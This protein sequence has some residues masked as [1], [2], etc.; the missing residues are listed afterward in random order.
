[1]SLGDD[2][3]ECVN[4]I[5]Q[6]LARVP[7]PDGFLS[8]HVVDLATGQ[9]LAGLVSAEGA[10]PDRPGEPPDTEHA[11]ARAHAAAAVLTQTLQD[12]GGV[13]AVHS[14][15]DDLEDLA[16]TTSRHHHLAQIL[17]ELAGT[18]AFLLVTLDRRRA[19]LAL[20]RHLLSRLEIELVP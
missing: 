17:P 20:A 9:V 19:N 10:A 7:R 14:V 11:H 5:E 1:M 18:D 16:I 13:L 15:E 12:L 2:S 8:A 4:V 6:V 3:E